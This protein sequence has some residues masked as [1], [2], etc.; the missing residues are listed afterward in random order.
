MPSLFVIASVYHAQLKRQMSVSRAKRFRKDR[1]KG[2]GHVRCVPV[3]SLHQGR[4]PV[5][6]AAARRLRRRRGRRRGAA[7]A[8][9]RAAGVQL[10]AGRQRGGE[11]RG[12]DLHRHRHRSRR[13][14]L[15]LLALRRRRPG[16]VRDHWG[17]GAVLRAESGFRI[18][19]RCRSEQYLSGAALGQ[20]RLHQRDARSRGHRH[21]CRAGRLPRHPSRR[22]LRQ[23]ALSGRG[24]G[25]VGAGVRRPAIGADPDPQSGDRRDR[26]DAVPRRFDADFDRRRARPAGL[27]AGAEFRRPRGRSTSS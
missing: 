12:D 14:S 17:G 9:Q 21:Q 20:R 7:A 1:A 15:D 24:A 4:F 27:R 5:F 23:P 19:R 25:R 26:A 22:R 18:P 6:G 8:R 2:C 3:A 16:P 11:Q 10:G 13:Q